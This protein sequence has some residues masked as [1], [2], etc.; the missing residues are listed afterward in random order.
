LKPVAKWKAMS[1]YYDEYKME[2][3]SGMHPSLHFWLFLPM[4]AVVSAVPAHAGRITPIQVG[5]PATA[6]ACFP[7]SPQCPPIDGTDIITGGLFCL[8]GVD[9]TGQNG[10]PTQPFT[11]RFTDFTY[12][13]AGN[14]PNGICNDAN[15]NQYYGQYIL[16]TPLPGSTGFQIAIDGVGT[17]GAGFGITLVVCQST[18][19]MGQGQPVSGIFQP[20]CSSTGNELLN[21]LGLTATV[22]P[23]GNISGSYGPFTFPLTSIGYVEVDL[24][25]L[26]G[27]PA[28]GSF[29]TFAN[30]IDVTATPEPASALL[31][32]VPLAVFIWRRLRPTYLKKARAI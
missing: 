28:D 18:P 26:G 10:L 30:S 22:G 5:G 15:S 16:P 32:G 3:T 2:G 1:V 6:P 25:P 9:C 4:V 23:G 14:D 20:G 29:M 24:A 7:V 11:F 8:S 31:V 17:P 21:T 12:T 27:F 19:Q 13:C